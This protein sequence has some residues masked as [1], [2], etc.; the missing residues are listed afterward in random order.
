[1]QDSEHI[2]TSSPR[3]TAIYALTNRPNPRIDFLVKED[4]NFI[5]Q[6][7]TKTK[8]AIRARFFNRNRI[9]LILT[10]FQIGSDSDYIFSTFWNYHAENGRIVFAL[11]SK[12]EDM[13]FHFYGDTGT[14]EQSMLIG[15]SFRNFFKAAIRQIDTLSSW[16]AEQFEKEKVEI[17][18]TYPTTIALWEAIK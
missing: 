3:G 8:I 13:A 11:M 7:T 1:M 14:I 17:L 9:G 16:S 4:S 15:N 2:I 5:K 12:Q 18:N 10:M 6:L